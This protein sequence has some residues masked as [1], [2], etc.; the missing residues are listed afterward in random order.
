MDPEAVIPIMSFQTFFFG[1]TTGCY[2]MAVCS[3]IEMTNSC[4]WRRDAEVT[5]RHKQNQ[6]GFS[7]TAVYTTT[8]QQHSELLPKLLDAPNLS[9]LICGHV[10]GLQS[11]ISQG[12]FGK[13]MPKTYPCVCTPA[14][15]YPL[16]APLSTRTA[17]PRAYHVVFAV[18]QPAAI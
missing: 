14:A 13:S 6:I 7:L 16:P 9:V 18:T 1:A 11:L 12:T 4:S 3:G 10:A 5:T 15:V 8:G 2:E 17:A